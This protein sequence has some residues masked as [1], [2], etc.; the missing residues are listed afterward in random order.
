MLCP[1][2][3][4]SS[5]HCDCDYLNINSTTN[6]AVPRRASLLYTVTRL[7]STENPGKV[8]PELT[9][10]ATSQHRRS[11][12]SRDPA[13]FRRHNTGTLPLELFNPESVASTYT[14][15]LSHPH[16]QPKPTLSYPPNLHNMSGSR[17][18]QIGGVRSHHPRGTPAK[19]TCSSSPP[20]VV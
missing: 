3:R 4:N 11:K 14:P 7:S 9:C 13:L 1:S 2:F 18:W 12:E 5:L 16:N 8:E 19:L 6:H 20:P 10:T 15:C 17:V